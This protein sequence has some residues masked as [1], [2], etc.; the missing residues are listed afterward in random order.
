MPKADPDEAN[1]NEFDP[2]VPRPIDRPTVLPPGGN[3][4]A[5]TG[6][7]AKIFAAP[8]DPADWPSWRADL[9][10]WRDESRTRLAYSGKAYE[11]AA[12]RWASRA[13]AVAQVWLWDERLFDHTGQKFT[14]DAFLNSIADQGG[15]DGLVLWHAYPIIG[16]DDR[17]QFDFYRDV[18]GLKDLVH[19]FHERGLRVFVDYNPWDTGT[20]RAK[21]DD[22]EELAALVSELG[23]DGVFLDTLKE[24]DARLTSALTTATPPQV[25][26]GESRVPNQRV[27]DHLLSWAQWFAD[28]QAPGVMR[29]HWYERRHMMHSIRR[30]NRDHSG[31]L[32]SAW[33]NGTGILVWDAVFGVWVGWNR[34]DEATLR[35]M[36][37]VQRAASDVLIDGDWSPLE[38]ATTEAI[39]A[40]MYVSRWTKD[41]TTLWTI[42]NRRDHDWTGDPL[43][44]P[45]PQGARRFDV[46]AGTTAPITVTV[47]ARGITGILELA[48]GADE[49][50]WLARL[51]NEAS[52]DPGSSD[53]TFPARQAIRVVPPPSRSTA[54]AT[55]TIRVD[56]GSHQLAVTYRRRE[57]GFYQ[58]APY[59]EEWKPLPPRLHDDRRETLDVTIPGP[60]A[61]ATREVSVAQFRSFL[62]TT[63]YE[64]PVSAR[65]LQGRDDISDDA[66][67]TGVSLSDARAYASWAGARLPNEFEW[68][69][70]AA[71]SHFQRRSPVVWNWTESEHSDGITRF[72]MLKGGS[73]HQSTGS[74][75]YTDGG[76]R[77]ETFTLKL[78]LAGLG[79]ERS[80]SI[81][82][83]IAWDLPT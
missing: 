55:E 10:A 80:P 47:P 24:G 14:V 40:G 56:P 49:P 34:R 45:L 15:L 75:W 72:A 42:V 48:P 6:D 11:N 28:S 77:D 71:Q 53:A 69:L 51:L 37:R 3:I 70:A 76:L 68:Q 31:E 18:P 81:G 74:D 79:V 19:Q 60:V 30:W 23:A 62:E 13:Y 66:P 21:R 43:A 50:E 36:L 41:G 65:F 35:R 78:L 1:T 25:L 44:A 46:T 9:A 26:E 52:K 33:M 22:A 57:T 29:A 39:S 64:P 63:G 32:Q 12:T 73:D 54:P 4:D 20:R 82:F 7:V 5:A 8:D 83:R 16:I 61:V 17:N 38:G 27:E 2:L 59:V 67:V 58:G